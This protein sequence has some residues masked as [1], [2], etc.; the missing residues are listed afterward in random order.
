MQ[1]TTIIAL[2]GMPGAGKSTCVEYLTRQ[3]I[4]SVYFGGVI[5]DETV[6]RYG[7]TSP[8]KEK[9]VREELRKKEG[10]GAVAKRVIPRL[11]DG[12]EKH[13]KVV[14]DGLY[15]W[16]EY[17]LLK[18]RFG[19]QLQ[20][21]AIAAP[22][23]LRHQRLVHRPLRPLTEDEVAKREFAEI[24]N[25]EKGG[26]IANADYTLLNDSDAETLLIDFEKLLREIEFLQ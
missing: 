16:T 17:K 2:V 25:I 13:G 14:A 15:S 6:K 5:V 7:K 19:E 9:I 18:R 10:M 22:R 12:L 1:K 4:P 11:E 24:E 21:V 23:H 26:P 20:I 8:D 3:G